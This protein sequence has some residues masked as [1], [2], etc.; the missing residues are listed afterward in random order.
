MGLSSES[1]AAVQ[2]ALQELDLDGWLL[3]GFHRQNP[4]A[5]SV[6]GV[7]DST[8]RY[9]ALL[10]SRGEPR[11]LTHSIDASLWTDWSW[12][13][14]HYRGWR[15][16]ERRIPELLKGCRRL[17]ME[18]S[19]EGA[20]PT[21]DRVP[22]GV[23]SF[24]ERLG[25]APSSSG[26][27]VT[28]FNSRWSEDQLARH[29]ETA[30]TLRRVAHE[31][32]RKAAKGVREGAPI[33][34]G[35]LAEWIRARLPDLGITVGVDCV[36]AAGSAASDPHYQ[37]RDSSGRPVG[38]GDVLLVDLW[39]KPSEIDVPAD[40]TWMAYLGRRVPDRVQAAWEA[41]RDAREAGLDLLDRGW[42]GGTSIRGFEVDEA[43]RSVIE[44]RGLGEYFVHRTGHSIDR[45]LHGSGPNLDGVETMDDRILL[46]GI[47]F[48][49]EPGV[50]VPGEFGLRSEVNVHLGS[51]GPEVTTPDPQEEILLLL[52]D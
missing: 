44:R 10:P 5:A 25:V 1:L 40:Q 35:E 27:L 30:K 9:F 39:G 47:G 17:A 16:L 31:A 29:R 45:E 22:A 50:Y 21:L 26:E 48:S 42:R 11:V 8:R 51:Q 37:P 6:L 7:D 41:V 20:I 15:D 36:V 23:M 24:L 3:F 38:E 12:P 43:C 34:E 32:F 28:I 33:R 14:L 2:A 4:V 52:E 46:P 13:V 19:P 49:V 18:T